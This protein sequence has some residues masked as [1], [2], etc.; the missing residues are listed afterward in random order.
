[1]KS[2]GVVTFIFCV[3]LICLI[4]DFEKDRLSMTEAEAGHQL[5]RQRRQTP[6]GDYLYTLEVLFVVDPAVVSWFKSQSRPGLDEKVLLEATNRT[7]L[8]S[9]RIFKSI[10]TRFTTSTELNLNI[11]LVDVI[12]AENLSFPSPLSFTPNPRSLIPAPEVLDTFRNWVNS[13][14][15]PNHD[16][17]LLFTGFNLTYGGS[18]SSTGLSYPDSVCTALAMSVVED[19]YDER[20]AIFAAQELGRSLGSRLDMDGNF[21]RATNLNIMST[22][23]AFNS[24]KTPNLWKFS[25]CSI[26]YIKNF[27]QKLDS[28]GTE[29]LRS[30]T[31][32]GVPLLSE[33]AKSPDADAQCRTAF[34][35]ESFLCRA[36][37]GPDYSTLCGGMSCY[38][39]ES[40]TCSSILPL[41]GTI[42]GNFTTCNGGECV[43]SDEGENVPDRCP[44]GD[45]PVVPGGVG[46]ADRV[47][48]RPYD[49]YLPSVNAACC[50]SCEEIKTDITGCEYGDRRDGCQFSKCPTYNNFTRENLCCLTCINGKLPYSVSTV[51]PLTSTSSES[52]F[53]V[54]DDAITT[55]NGTS[56]IRTT[57]PSERSSSVSILSTTD[58]TR[59]TQTST[60][61]ELQTTRISS[62]G[63]DMSSVLSTGRTAGSSTSLVTTETV[64]IRTKNSTPTSITSAIPSDITLPS[65]STSKDITSSRLTSEATTDSSTLH[66]TLLISTSESTHSESTTPRTT[67]GVTTTQTTTSSASDEESSSSEDSSEKKKKKDWKKKQKQLEKERKRNEKRIKALKKRYD[68]MMK[69]LRKYLELPFFKNIL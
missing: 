9:Q 49:C 56:L 29:C 67:S 23:F 64:T 1:M 46:C 41:D 28:D 35:L 42:C 63:P 25:R 2:F 5:S 44:F 48:G 68:K 61:S 3:V 21:C 22:K 51:L 19:F 4:F 43:L 69:R 11:V 55:E 24:P 20:T 8:H 32:T 40:T 18:A 17:A 47:Y 57:T 45:Q 62:T 13:T 34:G 15:L 33:V 58:S 50:L 6:A 65:T 60:T 54:S 27:L 14:E 16:H 36:L 38:S 10:K 7:K 59:V 37:T 52:V 30:H 53:N 31:A 66:T 39:P 26:S 12:I